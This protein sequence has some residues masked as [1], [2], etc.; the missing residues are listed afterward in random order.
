[1]AEIP[2][3]IP[4][5]EE[6]APLTMIEQQKHPQEEESPDESGTMSLAQ[7]KARTE[8]E[9]KQKVSVIHWMTGS[10]ATLFIRPVVRGSTRW[11]ECGYQVIRG[12]SRWYITEGCS[13]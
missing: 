12:S 11:Y 3:T 10:P 8:K 6:L 2:D 9:K 5:I 13:M 7:A 1:M 4:A